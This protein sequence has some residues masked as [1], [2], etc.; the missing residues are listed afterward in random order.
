M[1]WGEETGAENP[2]SGTLPVLITVTN[3]SSWLAHAA[4]GGKRSSRSTNRSR[5]LSIVAC[6]GIRSGRPHS[7]IRSSRVSR[8]V[9]GSRGVS[10]IRIGLVCPSGI[11]TGKF[12]KGARV[13]GPA[14][15]VNVGRTSVIL[16]LPLLIT[17]ITVSLNDAHSSRDG[18]TTIAGSAAM[19][20]V[21]RVAVMAM[22]N[23]FRR[24]S[25]L[26]TRSVS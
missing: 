10:R 7:L 25:L 12:C 23:R 3:V 2:V 4:S 22:R 13:N 15:S 18:N 5:A 26:V 16:P 11:V 21:A 6:R 24:G 14:P 8:N 19:P 9:P 17:L 20:G 1:N